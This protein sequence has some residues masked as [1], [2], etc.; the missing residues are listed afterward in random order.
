MMGLVIAINTISASL[1]NVSPGAGRP[2][3]TEY[4]GQETLPEDKKI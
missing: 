3:Q 4:L 2:P 1:L